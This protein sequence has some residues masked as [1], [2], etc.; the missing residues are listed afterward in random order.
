MTITRRRV[1]SAYDMK[2]LAHPVRLD[3]LELLTV[4]GSMTATEAAAELRQT[5]ANVSWH[6]RKLGDHGFVRQSTSGSGRRRPW[7][8]IAESLS[9]G[10][11]AE[12]PTLASALRDVAVDREVQLLR[13]A[14]ARHD[15]E[16]E[17]WQSA[18]SLNQSRLWL[19][20]D[21]AAELGEQ[22]RELILS[23]AERWNEPAARPEGSRL[24]AV[25]SWVV[26]HGPLDTT[27]RADTGEPR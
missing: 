12:D 16:S 17:Q 21:E 24:M 27:G 11:D 25:M 13:A 4:R 3:L 7:K 26:P 5:P 14:T 6:L 9:W 22:I 19:T 18:T 10:D 23:K 1:T 15:A 2:A 20:A 8:V